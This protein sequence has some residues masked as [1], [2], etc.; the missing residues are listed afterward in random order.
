MKKGESKLYKKPLIGVSI[1]AVMLLVL[2][3]LTIVVGYQSVKS[4]P[5]SDSPLFRLKLQGFLNHSEKR[6][7]IH[8]L[9]KGTNPENDIIPPVT[10]CILD[11]PEPNGKNGWY[12]SKI[13]IT[14]I[15]TDDNSGV[16][17]TNYQVDEEVWQ[18]Y[19]QPFNITT[20]SSK[21]TIQYFSVDNA[22]NIEPQK[23]VTFAM[24]RTRPM[25][26]LT[27][28]VTG[29]SNLTG[30]V[31]TFDATATDTTSEM[32]RVEFY[33]NDY[34]QKTIVGPGP[35]YLWD[36]PSS[37]MVR[38]FIRNPEIT[39]EYVKFYARLVII[40]GYPQLPP[41]V[42]ISAIAYDN[43]G[44]WIKDVIE[45]P[46]FQVQPIIKPGFYLFR[47]V[48]LPSNYTGYIGNYLIRASF[49][50]NQRKIT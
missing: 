45:T 44:N 26:M 47:D 18:T 5:M 35:E 43:A 31:I 7:K 21:H 9:E 39:E 16:N 14:L 27:Y 10:I 11:P 13:T 15:A 38:G 20:D 40:S 24:D 34:V 23:S 41:N 46:T 25:L 22:G 30:W 1:C 49:N 28:N 29:G 36:Y 12:V 3:S 42:V 8:Y 50:N 6:I 4:S 19:L 32:N 48:T 37:Y 2:S 17:I 33:I